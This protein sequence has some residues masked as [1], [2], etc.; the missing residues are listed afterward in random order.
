MEASLERG[1]E[2]EGVLPGSIGLRRQAKSYYR[3]TKHAGPDMQLT[4]M[5]TAYALAVSEENAGGGEIVTAPTCGSCGI[6]PAT[7]R[8]L[9]D[10]QEHLKENDLLRALATAGL[11]GMLLRL[12]HPFPGQKS[13]VRVRSVL[14]VLWL[15]QQ[16]HSLWAEHCAR[17]NM[18]RKWVLS[19]TWA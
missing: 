9:K 3:R 7:L 19:I 13:A 5:T 17:L 1:L 4:G 10:T 15:Q 8:Y 11:F 6:V 14:H 12:M 18:L 16:Q 2:A